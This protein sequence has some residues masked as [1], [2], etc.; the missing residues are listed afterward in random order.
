MQLTAH[1]A[2]INLTTT[3][4]GL[5]MPGEDSRAV[6][7]RGPGS[8]KKYM[9]DE[10]LLALHVRTKNSTRANDGKLPSMP[11]ELP[12]MVFSCHVGQFVQV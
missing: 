3:A 2:G 12:Y 6:K 11:A 10:Q 9:K 5:S 4:R 7:S 8:F 1:R